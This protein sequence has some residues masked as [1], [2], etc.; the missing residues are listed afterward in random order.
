MASHI[1]LLVL[2]RV[3]A[4]RAAT[5]SGAYDDLLMSM[6]VIVTFDLHG[7]EPQRYRDMKRKL[8][9]L[10]LAKHIRL[11]NGVVTKLPA[12]TFA[13]KYRGRWTTLTAGQLQRH[14]RAQ[15]RIAVVSLGLRAT[16]LVSVGKTWSWGRFQVAARKRRRRGH[17]A[18]LHHRP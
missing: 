4:R 6:L 16:G 9:A 12:N 2:Q 1:T 8:A 11:K 3:G 13:A 7:A 14:V 18:T 17:R 5:Q 10:R 15:V